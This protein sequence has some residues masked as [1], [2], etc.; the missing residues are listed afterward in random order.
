MGGIALSTA[1]PE[2][3]LTILRDL[4]REYTEILAD[5]SQKEKIALWKAL[6]HLEPVRPMIRLSN[7]AW[8]QTLPESAY[9]CTDDYAREQERFFRWHLWMWRHLQ[10]DFVFDDALY[11]PVVVRTGSWGV[12]VNAVRPDHIFGA[13]HFEPVIRT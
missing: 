11:V 5:P 7:S 13:A 6:N 3:D 9:V 8:D 2:A 4:A 12:E 10:D 1:I